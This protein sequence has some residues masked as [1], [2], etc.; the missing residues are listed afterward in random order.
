MGGSFLFSVFLGGMLPWEI[1]RI[2]EIINFH[3]I[4]SSLIS[5]GVIILVTF[6]TLLLLCFLRDT[7]EEWKELNK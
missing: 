3:S 4:G 1:G 5:F 7:I 2:S 6:A